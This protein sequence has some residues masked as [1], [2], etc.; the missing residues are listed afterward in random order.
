MSLAEQKYELINVAVLTPHPKNPNKGSLLDIEESIDTNGFYGAVIAQKSSGHILA[1][2]H[3]WQAAKNL[4]EELVPVIWV[5]V[6]DERAL[7]ILLADNRTRDLAK[8]DN[9]LLK[10]IL[11]G[12]DDLSGTGFAE[13]LAAAVEAEKEAIEDEVSDQDEA[14][15]SEDTEPVYGVLVACDSQEDAEVFLRELLDGRRKALLNGRPA[16][17]VVA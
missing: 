12:L 13:T 14:P 1:G 5:D 4:G 2:H 17:V 6:S 10:E 9:A 7:K 8:Y 15:I 16:T 11:D 3:R